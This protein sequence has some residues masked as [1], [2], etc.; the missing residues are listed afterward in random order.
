[1]C[2]RTETGPHFA[3]GL[4]RDC[5]AS[6]RDCSNGLRLLVPVEE[7]LAGGG[8]LAVFGARTGCACAEVRARQAAERAKRPR[9]RLAEVVGQ[10]RAFMAERAR[11]DETG[12]GGGSTAA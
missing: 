4:E 8:V 7:D 10:G 5:A 1:M 2:G 6:K 12:E 3:S 11:R 9:V